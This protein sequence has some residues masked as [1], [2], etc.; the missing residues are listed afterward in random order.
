MGEAGKNATMMPAIPAMGSV[1]GN[2]NDAVTLAI[3]GKQD[4][5]AALTDGATKIRNLIANPL[6]GMV[7]VPGS[8]Q[9]QAGCSGDWQPE[10]AATQMTKGDDGIWRSGP[11]ALKAG[12]YE[13]K[14][15]LDGS[16]TTNYGVD[17]KADGDNYKFT[18]A[19]DGEVSFEF[20][21][22]SKLLTIILP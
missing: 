1:W 17:G 19:A 6:T 13:G 4:A 11:F 21:P 8:Y 18:L 5:E 12:D 3:Q 16:W 9:A 2:W 22:E 15:A 7:N 14:V 20:D 10:C